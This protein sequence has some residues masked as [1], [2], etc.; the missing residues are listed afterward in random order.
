MYEARHPKPVLY[1]NLVGWG[2]ERKWRG[3]QDGGETYVYGQF[4]LIYGKKI[5][6][7][8]YSN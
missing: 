4:I 5:I 6:T 3:L 1:D 2:G 7:K 8:L